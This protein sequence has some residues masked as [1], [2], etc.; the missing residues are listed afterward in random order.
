MHVV[1]IDTNFARQTS[2]ESLAALV[3]ETAQR[4]YLNDVACQAWEP[5]GD[6]FLSPSLMEAELIE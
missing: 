3:T 1:D 2:R 6:E 5:A 4:W